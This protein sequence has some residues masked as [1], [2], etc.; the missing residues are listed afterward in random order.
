MA[1]TLASALE[2]L[3]SLRR[4]TQRKSYYYLSNEGLQCEERLPNMK[5]M[6]TR[7]ETNSTGTQPLRKKPAI[8]HPS[9]LVEVVV[10]VVV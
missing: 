7:K 5:S 4:H 9:G 2:S 3:A 8:A 10:D 6:E 1:D